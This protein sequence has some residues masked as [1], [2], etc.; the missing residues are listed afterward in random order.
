MTLAAQHPTLMDR[1]RGAT[2]VSPP[3]GRTPLACGA[4]AGVAPGAVLLGDAAGFIDPVTGGG[5][6]QALLSAELLAGFLPRILAER[7]RDRDSEW[8]WRFDRQRRA[9]LRDYRWLTAALLLVTRRPALARATLHLMRAK[10]AAMGH[11]VGVAAGLRR[12]TP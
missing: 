8:L 12:L 9:M 11:L 3:R 4:Q 2:L 6:A 10:P 7:D 5:I 1:L